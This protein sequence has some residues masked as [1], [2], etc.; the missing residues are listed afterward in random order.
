M[1]APA[2]DCKGGH[3][4]QALHAAGR[5]LGGLVQQLA[6]LQVLCRFLS[7]RTKAMQLYLE[8][9]RIERSTSSLYSRTSANLC[10]A[11]GEADHGNGDDAAANRQQFAKA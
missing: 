7:G 8:V 10:F 11:E 6:V 1:S 5:E 2:P 4:Q 3:A 9:T